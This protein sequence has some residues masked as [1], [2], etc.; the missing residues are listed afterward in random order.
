MS[1]KIFIF[2]DEEVVYGCED[3]SLVIWKE[4]TG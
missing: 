4:V 3:C 1:K 2:K